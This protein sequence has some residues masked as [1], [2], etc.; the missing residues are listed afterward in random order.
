MAGCARVKCSLKRELNFLVN[1]LCGN[2]ENSR[3]KN[4]AEVKHLLHGG[5]VTS[6]L[7]YRCSALIHIS[8]G[9][10]CVEKAYLF[11]ASIKKGSIES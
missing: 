7:L 8:T 5:S 6:L 9:E 11:A 10:G 2:R 4:I 1:T 3:S